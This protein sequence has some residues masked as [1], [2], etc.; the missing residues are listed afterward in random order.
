[1]PEDRSRVSLTLADAFE[2]IP[3]GARGS[4]T[5]E[6]VAAARSSLRPSDTDSWN[7]RFEVLYSR[8]INAR[9]KHRIAA[10][11]MDAV[12][13]LTTDLRSGVV[14]YYLLEALTGAPLG[15]RVETRGRMQVH[16]LSNLHAVFATL[17]NLGIK[18]VNIGANDVYSGNLSCIFGLLWTL[19]AAFAWSDQGGDA[20]AGE[21]AGEAPGAYD[22]PDDELSPRLRFFRVDEARLLALGTGRLVGLGDLERRRRRDDGRRRS[23]SLASAFARL[24]RPRAGDSPRLRRRRLSRRAGLGDGL[25]GEGEAPRRLFGG[26]EAPRRLEVATRASTSPS[27]TTSAVS[28]AGSCAAAVGPVFKAFFTSK[29]AASYEWFHAWE[30]RPSV[31]AGVAEAPVASSSRPQPLVSADV[32]VAAVASSAGL[33][34]ATADNGAAGCKDAAFASSTRLRT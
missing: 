27:S 34:G 28:V 13:D 31:T 18:T 11:E 2:G 4:D 23:L 22:C 30:P 21:A 25:R 5:R 14:L 32:G 19:M 20:A 26:G 3:A 33:R 9:L 7:G 1:M 17:Q 16:A 8:W 29:N 24:L 12:T 6:T 15:R 10:G